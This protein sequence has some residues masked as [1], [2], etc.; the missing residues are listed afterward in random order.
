MKNSLATIAKISLILCLL[1]GHAL[2]QNYMQNYQYSSAITEFK[3]ALRINYLDN[4]AR[5]NLVNAYLARASEYGNKDGAWGKAADDFRSAL[6]YLT[7]YPKNQTN[8][9]NS[10][11]VIN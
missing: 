11:V 3:S 8:I 9:Q 2:G 4:S 1:N 7:Y 5:I 10:A 6:F